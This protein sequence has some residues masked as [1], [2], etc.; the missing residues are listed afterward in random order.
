MAMTREGIM[1]AN[2]GVR[3]KRKAQVTIPKK[4]MDTLH[5]REND[6]LD[7]FVEGDKI[8]LRPVIRVPKD[9]AWFW[10][11]EWQKEEHEADQDIELG[12]VT[13]FNSS[14]EAVAFLDRIRKKEKQE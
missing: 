12:R 3:I 2:R 14:K 8:V 9:Q 11:E 7:V 10:T 5:L 1:V 4:I 6:E 13:A